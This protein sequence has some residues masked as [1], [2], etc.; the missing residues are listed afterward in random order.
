MFSKNPVTKGSKPIRGQKTR[1]THMMIEDNF[2]GHFVTPTSGNDGRSITSA[3]SIAG[4][5]RYFGFG[6]YN[7]YRQF[8]LK[9]LYNVDYQST[10]RPM[11]TPPE[12]QR[13]VQHLL[14]N[15]EAVEH[16][17]IATASL[18]PLFP[19]HLLEAELAFQMATKNPS[20]PSGKDSVSMITQPIQR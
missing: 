17:S 19:K 15:R 2:T 3:S 5:T 14:A 6:T 9:W 4:I 1:T 8:H 13:Q 12:I 18:G 16:R 11:E 20:N 10:P 7:S